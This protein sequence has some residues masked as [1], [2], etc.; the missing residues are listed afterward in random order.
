MKHSN[1]EIEK[2]SVDLTN[3]ALELSKLFDNNF[4]SLDPAKKLILKDEISESW[5]RL[6]WVIKQ[7]EEFITEYQVSNMLN[8]TK[9]N[10]VNIGYSQHKASFIV[11]NLY[12]EDIKEQFESILSYGLDK[13]IN[14]SDKELEIEKIKYKIITSTIKIKYN[15][16]DFSFIESYFDSI[17]YRKQ[18]Y[19]IKSKKEDEKE[20]I[21]LKSFFKD[22]VDDDVINDIQLDFQSF[23][24]KKMAIIISLLENEFKILRLIDNSNTLSRKNFIRILKR[25]DDFCYNSINKYF[26]AGINACP[27]SA[28]SKEYIELKQRLNEIIIKNKGD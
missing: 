28:T 27:I 21:T 3:R 26:V 18:L 22:D 13:E 20:K 17:K 24:G 16:I 5:N 12:L 15:K 8:T 6:V 9:D 10:L 4:K 11:F 1:E 19:K 23:E 14:K 25:N 2:I 7:V